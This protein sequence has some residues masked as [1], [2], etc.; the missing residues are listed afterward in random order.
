MT[1]NILSLYFLILRK[2]DFIMAE[3][4]GIIVIVWALIYFFDNMAP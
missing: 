3:L 1:V 4:V 2:E